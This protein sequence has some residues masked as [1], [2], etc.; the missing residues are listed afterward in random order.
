[1]TFGFLLLNPCFGPELNFFAFT[2]LRSL[3]SIPIGRGTLSLTSGSLSLKSSL[4]GL[5]RCHLRLDPHSHCRLEGLLLRMR[6]TQA[7]VS[8]RLDEIGELAHCSIYR[9]V[10]VSQQVTRGVLLLFAYLGKDLLELAVHDC[11]FGAA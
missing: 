4:L 5:R 2:L 10:Y 9:P 3:R 11:L 8:E 6:C 1:M 7:L